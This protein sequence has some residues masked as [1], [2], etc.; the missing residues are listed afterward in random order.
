MLTFFS[1]FNLEK[2]PQLLAKNIYKN[3][4]APQLIKTAVC[5]TH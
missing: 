3:E 1:I 2:Y 5:G 4:L